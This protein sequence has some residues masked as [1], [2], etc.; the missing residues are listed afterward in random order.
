MHQLSFD[1]RARGADGERL[2]AAW[3]ERAGC[4]ILARNYRCAAGEVDLVVEDQ[5]EL[6]FVEVRIRRVG[7]MV[8]PEESVTI[9]K[10][11]RILRAAERYLQATQGMDRPW[12]VDLVA[13]EVDGAGR[14]QRLERVRS[15]IE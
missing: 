3:L 15:V 13:V 2:A 9:A 6:V 14:V 1:R 7:G 10:Q 8:G 11:R 5:G 4:R 12:R